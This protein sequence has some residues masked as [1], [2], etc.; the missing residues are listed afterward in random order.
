MV[1][2]SDEECSVGPEKLWIDVWT[3]AR[4]RRCP[5]VL[6]RDLIGAGRMRWLCRSGIHTGGHARNEGRRV[7]IEVGG[8]RLNRFVRWL[9]R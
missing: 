5:K 8:R 7:R 4:R 3:S 6:W 2:A 9:R 1:R